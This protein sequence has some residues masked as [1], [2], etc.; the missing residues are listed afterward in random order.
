MENEN[1]LATQKTAQKT[2]QKTTQKNF[3]LSSAQRGILK[4]LR[5]NPTASRRMISEAISGIT[6]D[7]IK[8]N[9][10][11]LQEIG[12]LRRVGPDKGG[13]WEVVT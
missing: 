5:E 6:A 9:L 11:R 4:F 2:T 13:H 7:G 1:V 3:S 8:Y 12:C 10:A